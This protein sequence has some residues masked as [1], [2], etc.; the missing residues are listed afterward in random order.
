L[1]A[2]LL[3]LAGCWTTQPSLKPPPAPPEWILPPADDPR[4]SEPVS[5]P[6]R[7]LNEGLQKKDSTRDAG[8]P[9]GPRINPAQQ[10]FGGMG[11]SGM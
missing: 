5:Y 8:L 3:V 2:A 1:G 4:F 9:G 6:E 10:R 7:V 11:G